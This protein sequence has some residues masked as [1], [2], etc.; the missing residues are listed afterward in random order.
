MLVEY[1][2]ALRGNQ[3]ATFQRK[4]LLSSSEFSK[5]RKHFKNR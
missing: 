2:T 5:L 1:D 3:I 4:A